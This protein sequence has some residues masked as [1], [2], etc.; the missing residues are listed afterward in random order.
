MIP[1]HASLSMRMHSHS[2]QRVTFAAW[3]LRGG[4]NYSTCPSGS[5]RDENEAEGGLELSQLSEATRVL[6]KVT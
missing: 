3:L 5:C 6:L 4:A 2:E 1:W